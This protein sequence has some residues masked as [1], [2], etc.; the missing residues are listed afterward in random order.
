MISTQS[1]AKYAGQNAMFAMF[2]L[3]SAELRDRLLEQWFVQNVSAFTKLTEKQ[4]YT[5]NCCIS[6]SSEED[7]CPFKLSNLTFSHFSAFL[8]Q[9]KACKGKHVGKAMSLGNESY[10]QSQ[11]ALKH[12]FRMSKY[13][14]QP[15]FFNKLRQ[16]T[17]G[18]RRHVADK[19]ALEGDVAIVEKKKMGF[20][21][22]KTICELF[23]KE[24]HEEF[25]FAR[26]FLTLEWNLMARSE[27]VVHAHILHVHWEDD[28]FVF[29]FVKSK[30]DQMGRNRDQ[31]WHV[32]A[33][34]HNPAICPALALGCYIF[35]NPGAFSSVSEDEPLNEQE[36]DEDLMEVEAQGA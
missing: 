36:D 11:S 27:N 5:K 7:N 6:M 24:E 25:I 21:V 17:K 22:F 29:R 34:P 23:M 18:I 15:D 32:Y 13:T 26:A 30:G 2:C 28:C 10:S 4:K 16:F 14:M 20:N 1:T 12:L 9:K 35:S 8:T 19:K 31:E 33:N 3:D